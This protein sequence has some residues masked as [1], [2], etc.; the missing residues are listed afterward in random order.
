[1]KN[2]TIHVV[3]MLVKA[4]DETEAINIGKSTNDK[5]YG[6][7]FSYFL[8]EKVDDNWLVVLAKNEK[9]AKIGK[10]LFHERY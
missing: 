7:K 9:Q 2:K 5:M 1:M 3:P 6:G 4:D 8:T 10:K